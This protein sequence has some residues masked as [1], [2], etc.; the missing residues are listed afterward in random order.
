MGWIT[1]FPA[2]ASGLILLVLLT[3]WLAGM[4]ALS[5]DELPHYVTS[6]QEVIGMALMLLLL[7]PYFVS[8]TIAQR[9]H[10]LTLIEE[11]RPLVRHPEDCDRAREAIT[12]GWRTA[13][14]PGLL[15]GLVMGLLNT[16]PLDAWTS[17]VGRSVHLGLSAGQMFLWLLIGVALVIGF[18]A[19]SGFRRLGEVVHFEL[20][21][22]DR[23]KPL[24]RSGLLDMLVIAGALA[25]T[26]LQSLDAEFRWYNYQFGLLVAGVASILLVVWPL[27][28]I[29]VR[30]RAEKRRR[31][32][33]IDAQIAAAGEPTTRAETVELETLLSHRDRLVGLR[34]WLFS[35]DLVSRFLL[36]LIIPPLAWVGAAI[37]ERA[38]DLFLAG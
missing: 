11:L 36:Y 24:A 2:T 4:G 17:T 22:L 13:F 20:F 30:I 1:R 7:P 31:I 26:P 33:A 34:A 3:L 10:S 37:V 27:W 25:F 15:I 32:A 18:K 14:L 12:R 28:P 9:R 6:R 19:S 5:P 8:A 21:R 38:V 23:L 35:T 16:S 29:H